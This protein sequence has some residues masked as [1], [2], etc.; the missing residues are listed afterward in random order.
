MSTPPPSHV[1]P[2]HTRSTVKPKSILIVTGLSG[3]GKSTSLRTLEDSGWEVVDNFP[4]VLLDRLLAAPVAE[5]HDPSEERPLAIGIDSRTRGFDASNIVERAGVLRADGGTVETLFLDCSGSV[6]ERR[7][8][9][10]RRR[11]P[12][13]LDRPAS[14]GVAR[15][16]ELMEP[17]RRHADHIVDTSDLN[18]NALQQEIRARFGQGMATTLT[19]LS[20][21]YSRGVPRNADLVFDMRFLRNPHWVPELRPR[22]GLETDVAAYVTADPLYTLVTGQI[23]ALLLTVLPRYIAE[24]KAYVTVAFGCTGGR[25]RS[26]CVAKDMAT[27]LHN[28][29][30]SPT[31]SH[32]NLESQ[33]LEAYEDRRRGAARAEMTS[34]G[35]EPTA[36][37]G[38]TA[39]A[40]RAETERGTGS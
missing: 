38:R 1:A 15:E 25:H 14:D 8:A 33:P 26:V 40:E 6:L 37:G 35:A 19:I 28:A 12:L 27:R 10:T 29:G 31:L 18:V 9:E 7:F 34:A 20:F 4:L 36:D 30:F 23:E 24:G 11:H 3:A 5:G 13:A 21:G 22:T 39:Q 16:R 32:R 17:L 2:S